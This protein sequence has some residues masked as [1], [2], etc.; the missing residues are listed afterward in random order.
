MD[1]LNHCNASLMDCMRT[2]KLKLKPGKAKALSVG[3]S[4][5]WMGWEVACLRE[6]VHSLGLLT[7]PLLLFEI[8]VASVVQCPPSAW[9]DGPAVP[10][11]GQG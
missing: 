3:G 8:Q 9:A 11:S 2:N 6:L 7:D 10:Q 1:M 4:L 5:D